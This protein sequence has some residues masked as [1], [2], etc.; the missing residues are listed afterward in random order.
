MCTRG[1][2]AC[3]NHLSTSQ[4][5]RLLEFKGPTDPGVQQPASCHLPSPSVSGSDVRLR[6]NERNLFRKPSIA[7][8]NRPFTGPLPLERTESSLFTRSTG[9]CIASDGCVP[10]ATDVL[11]TGRAAASEVKGKAGTAAASGSELARLSSAK[12]SSSSSPPRSTEGQDG[13]SS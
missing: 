6:P 2:G 3:E 13:G 10:E 12:A 11:T 7:N 4:Q 5:W 9:D 1:N 8:D